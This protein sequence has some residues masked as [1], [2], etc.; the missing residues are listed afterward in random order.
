MSATAIAVRPTAALNFNEDQVALIK[1]TIAVGATNDEL[2][3]FLH[4]AQRTGLDPMSRQIYAIKRGGKMTIQT[5]IDGFRLVAE[6]TGQ[7]AGQ[8]GPFWCGPDGQWKD[9]WL[10]K[11]APAAAK[12]G[13]LRKDF[14]EPLW[15]VANYDGYAQEFNGV[16]S[17]L[18][19]KMPALMLAKCAES[20]ALRRAFPQELSGLYTGDEMSQADSQEPEPSRQIRDDVNTLTGEFLAEEVGSPL[21]LVITDVQTRKVGAKGT[22]R[23]EVT[24]SDG[25]TYGTISSAVGLSA[26]NLMKEGCAVLRDLEVNGKFTNL[27]SVKRDEPEMFDGDF[28]ASSPAEAPDESEIPF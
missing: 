21:A 11:T 15:S 1:R 4:Q 27:K 25:E 10:E 5:A 28:R 7:Y 16:P 9:V 18:W 6:R 8:L 3:L 19:K 12:V 22:T 14:A 13:V 24:F 23:Y 20:L 2:S 17:G 26:Q